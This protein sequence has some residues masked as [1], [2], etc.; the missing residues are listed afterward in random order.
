MILRF[1]PSFFKNYLKNI[2]QKII[3]R[4]VDASIRRRVD[5][6]KQHINNLPFRHKFMKGLLPYSYYAYGVYHAA[7]L[8]KRLDIK[9]ISV[10]EFGVAGGNGLL[11]LE[12]HAKNVG[13]LLGIE[14]EV[15]GFDTGSGMTPPKSYLDMPYRFA[16]GN[17]KMNIPELMG[18]L[19]N[20][21][22]VI[23][24]V[25]ETVEN[26]FEKYQP[27]PIGFVSFDMD[28]YWSTMD[29]LHL[30]SD[31]HSAEY[32]LPRIQLYFDDING[33]EI[34]SYNEFVGELAAI[35]DWNNRSERIKIGKGRALL[36]KKNPMPWY[37]QMYVMHRFFH[38]LYNEY[39]SG[40][41]EN[42]LRLK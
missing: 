20:A 39:V 22:L 28:Y 26:F 42:S 33:H 29:G 13:D 41:T 9:R 1:I 19:N 4:E 34:S 27:A 11:C 25:R 30:F 36:S 12:D 38:P 31:E 7:V 18:R 37:S 5:K 24:D 16:E 8:A 21:K 23:G 3:E 17:Y 15:Y 6:S 10:I 40:A 32:F 2:L 35:N 14:I